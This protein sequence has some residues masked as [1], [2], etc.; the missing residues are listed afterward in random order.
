MFVAGS[1]TT[2]TAIRITM[3]YILSAPL[4]Y[5]RLKREISE[6]VR[7]GRASSPIKQAEAKTLPYLQVSASLHTTYGLFR[8]ITS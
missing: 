4:V 8:K 2:A 1:D 3:L 6:A 5:H 7:D